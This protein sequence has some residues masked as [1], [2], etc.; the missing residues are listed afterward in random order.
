M[1]PCQYCK[2]LPFYGITTDA[3]S[4]CENAE[5]FHIRRYANGTHYLVCICDYGADHEVPVF[6]CPWCGRKLIDEEK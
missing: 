1:E 2:L 6:H 5:E 4:F 3:D